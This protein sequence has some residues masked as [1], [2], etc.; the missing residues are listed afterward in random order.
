MLIPKSRV[1]VKYLLF[2]LI[3]TARRMVVAVGQ[4][5]VN[6]LLVFGSL[7]RLGDQRA[8]RLG[9]TPQTGV[10]GVDGL[11]RVGGVLDYTRAVRHQL[12]LAL[13]LVRQ[14]FLVDV[15]ARAGCFK[16]GLVGKIMNLFH[17]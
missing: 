4:L 11:L 10:L 7:L 12:Q 17:K 15:F 8:V 9:Q 5:S 3:A 1:D 2:D 13:R 6:Q 14:Q 16:V